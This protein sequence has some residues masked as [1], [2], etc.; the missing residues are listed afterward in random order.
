MYFLDQLLFY[1]DLFD[2]DVVIEFVV[3]V[4]KFNFVT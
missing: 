3:Y 4:F 2:I 1:F